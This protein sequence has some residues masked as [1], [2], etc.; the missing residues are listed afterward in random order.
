MCNLQLC[1]VFTSPS[2][3]AAV[4]R[5]SIDSWP[6]P[7]NRRFVV[8]NFPFAH[9]PLSFLASLSLCSLH[10]TFELRFVRGVAHNN[11]YNFNL[12]FISKESSS[13]IY[14][15][16]RFL[17]TI[18]LLFIQRI[19]HAHTHKEFAECILYLRLFHDFNMSERDLDQNI[20]NIN[21]KFKI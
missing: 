6:A 19:S 4:G 14:S 18:L 11:N 12:Q 16:Y 15:I 9:F 2:L 7:C 21:N 13:Y 1:C 8:F 5:I 3:S 20:I 17:Y 10:L